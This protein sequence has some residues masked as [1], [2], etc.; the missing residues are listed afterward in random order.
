VGAAVRLTRPDQ[1]LLVVIVFTVGGLMGRASSGST[2]TV[3]WALGV[4]AVAL[5]AVSV[6]AANEYADADT[7]ARTTRTRFSGGSGAISVHGLAR[8][9]A[10]RIAVATGAAGAAVSV[11]LAML[12]LVPAAVTAGMVVGLVL[13]WQ[14]S[15]PPLALARHGAGEVTNAAL[16]GLLL[17]VTGAVVMGAPI[18]TAVAAFVP[19]TLLVFVNLLETQWPDRI[20]DR[21]VG[22]NTLTS[23]LSIGSLRA[24]AAAVALA[25][26]V[27]LLPL[28][29]AVALAALAALPL[30]VWGVLSMGRRPPGPSVLAMVVSIVAQGTAWA[31]LG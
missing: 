18:G 26:Y 30:S 11:G 28:P 12:G 21:A 25:A 23:G 7:D 8:S 29:P 5:V 1:V 13:G 27:S 17:P 10:L 19:F 9:W 31:A 2:D 15:L 22:K 3:A 16:G 24:L 14:Y 20:A 6:H 4:T